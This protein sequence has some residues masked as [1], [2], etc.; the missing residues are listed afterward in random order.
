MDLVYWLMLL[1]IPQV[2]CK[3]FYSA[4]EYF[5][6]PR[7]IFTA[8]PKQL[9]ASKIFRASSIEHILTANPDIAADDLAWQTGESCHI[10]TL[11][12]EKYP[13]ILKQITDP[14]PILYARGN[15]DLL[16]KQQLAIVGSRNP[17]TYGAD[18]AYKFAYELAD[19]IIITSGMAMGIDSK[20]HIGALE[21]GNP[22]IAVCGTGLDRIYPA[23]NSNLAKQIAKSGLLVSELPIG[24]KPL[25]A[26]FP[27]R[28]RIITGMSAGVLVVEALDK[29]GSMISARSSLEQG[30]EVFAIP[31][32]I[33]NPLAIGPH[34]LIKDGAAL[35]D[36]PDDIVNL[37]D[38][39]N[40]N[41]KNANNFIKNTPTSDNTLLKYLDY[42]GISFDDLVLKSGLSISEISTNLLE[43]EINDIIYQNN[44]NYILRK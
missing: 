31:N 21:S 15:L 3:T 10:L 1:K 35:V 11:I 36:C 29:S 13:Q 25:A 39:S 28:N 4:L 30:R 14:P 18:N 24:T 41:D 12:D 23:S 7:L 42:D 27:R 22:T 8:T 34:S 9:V 40:N 44:N 20:A 26:N 19:K 2:G 32:S 17:S 5:T 33:N 16:N 43:L 37:L 6:E 38:L